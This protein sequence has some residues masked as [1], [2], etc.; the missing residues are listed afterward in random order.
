MPRSLWNGTIAFGHVAVPVKLYSAVQPKTV[1]FRE[2]HLGDEAKIEHRRFCSAEER[3]VPSEEVVRGFE[4]ADGEYVVLEKDEIAAA[5]GST[6]HVVEIE[7]F[8]EA[9]A[10]DPVFHEKAYYLGPGK[11]GDDGYRLFHDALEAAGRAGIGR[12]T[13]HNREYL[14][15]IRPFDGVL[16]LHTLRFADEV[17]DGS[18]LDFDPPSRKPRDREVEMAAQLVESLHEEF[19]PNARHD[20]YREA[21]LDMIDRKA[22]GKKLKRPKEEPAEDTGDLTAALEASLAGGRR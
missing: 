18:E 16:A 5:A 7:A 15:A 19:D 10:I 14:A 12:F 21:V 17:V 1:R 11:D 3:E 6:A 22:K 9:A 4:I 2:V 8:V 13:F 20:E